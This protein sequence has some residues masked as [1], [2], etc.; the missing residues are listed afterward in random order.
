MLSVEWSDVEQDASPTQYYYYVW[1]TQPFVRYQPI[2]I[3]VER[4]N[5]KS[6][7][8]VLNVVLLTE[9]NLT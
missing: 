1:F 3:R 7:V 5:V 8:P 6:E 9:L 2:Q 4:N